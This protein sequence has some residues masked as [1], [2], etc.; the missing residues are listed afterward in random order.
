MVWV[1]DWAGIQGK[2]GPKCQT[3]QRRTQKKEKR[4][5]CM[6]NHG[7]AECNDAK[8]NPVE[9]LTASMVPGIAV[10]SFTLTPRWPGSSCGT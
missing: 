3:V 2:F 5:K 4:L 10:V 7:I 1:H 8:K 9:I 6:S